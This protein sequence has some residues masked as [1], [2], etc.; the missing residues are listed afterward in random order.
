MTGRSSS[1]ADYDAAR[2]PFAE[3]GTPRLPI[4]LNLGAQLF[5]QA[6]GISRQNSPRV[7][8]I[9]MY[10]QY[11]AY[12]LT[13]VLA[14]E[15]T[16][17]GCHTD[18]WNSAPGDFS[19]LVDRQ[20]WRQLMPPLRRASDRLGPVLPDDRRAR[21]GSTRRRR[22]IAAS[23]IPTPRCCRTCWPGRSRSPSSRPEPG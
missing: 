12:R 13:G 3:T 18:L 1:A 7:A 21:P 9:L 2:P 22:S 23:T 11:W 17:L 20:G 8:R 14:N 15:V 10:P 19:T 16:S 5:W 6:A 4:G